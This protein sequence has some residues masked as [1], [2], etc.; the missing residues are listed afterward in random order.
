MEPLRRHLV[1]LPQHPVF[2]IGP[3]VW[4]VQKI[5]G[6]NHLNFLLHYGLHDIEIVIDKLR[7]L[8]DSLEHANQI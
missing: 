8:A 1:D 4:H 2:L 3:E 5:A 7:L 6:G